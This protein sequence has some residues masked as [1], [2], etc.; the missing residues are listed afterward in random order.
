VEHVARM[1]HLIST[2]KNWED[3]ICEA[4]SADGKDIEM[5]LHE[6]GAPVRNLSRVGDCF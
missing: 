5:N 2:Y 6:I 1:E 4:L 3:T